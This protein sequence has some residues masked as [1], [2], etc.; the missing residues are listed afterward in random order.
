L[1][2]IDQTFAQI[3]FDCLFYIESIL[4]ILRSAQVDFFKLIGSAD[5]I[6]AFILASVVIVKSGQ[7][8]YARTL[9]RRNAF[10]KTLNKISCGNP[11]EYVNSLL[12]KPVYKDIPTDSVSRM[13][14]ASAYGWV[15]IHEENGAVVAY[16]FTR[17]S[18]KFRY[19]LQIQTFGNIVGRLGESTFREMSA[20]FPEAGRAYV[21]ASVAGYTE[22]LY[23]GRPGCYQHYGLSSVM[24]GWDALGLHIGVA[25]SVSW[26]IFP[27]SD[28][29][30]GELSDDSVMAVE[31]YRS[32][33]AP[34][35]FVVLG[36]DI[37]LFS[38]Y[39]ISSGFTLHFD[40]LMMLDKER[41][42]HRVV[43][44]QKLYMRI[45]SWMERGLGK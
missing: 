39:S 40:M 13:L 15:T 41:I 19:G 11:V 27:L 6:T 42:R 1:I 31:R 25:G 32:E 7:A 30:T 29:V 45:R 12:G 17:T 2:A 36:S 9:G 33:V 44:E 43:G 16:S 22:L 3:T 5:N 14:Y 4:Q 34:D 28:G 38:Q 20:E 8:A 35:T 23:F 37:D 24:E 10:A 18:K 21:G 26:G